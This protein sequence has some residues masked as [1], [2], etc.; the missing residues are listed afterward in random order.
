MQ[1]IHLLIKHIFYCLMD[2]N[3]ENKIKQSNLRT[4][5]MSKDNSFLDLCKL[6]GS[7]LDSI[8]VCHKFLVWTYTGHNV[9]VLCQLVPVSVQVD[10][11]NQFSVQAVNNAQVCEVDEATGK[12]DITIKTHLHLCATTGS[13]F[14]PLEQ[15]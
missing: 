10:L 5:I 7:D 13:S 14:N 3:A 8:E 15:K 9:V 4:P 2:Q 11:F 6:C 1:H 12:A